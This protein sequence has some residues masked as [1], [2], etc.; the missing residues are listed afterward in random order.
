[1][2]GVSPS[3]L[4]RPPWERAPPLPPIPTHPRA[5]PAYFSGVLWWGVLVL[6]GVGSGWC[7][8]VCPVS[9][10]GARVALRQTLRGRLRTALRK[11]LRRE[12]RRVL[13]PGVRPAL[14]RRVMGG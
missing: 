14:R 13:C 7:R 8:V 9:R 11:G 5:F 3:P 10:P 12:L 6:V 2:T 1:M 4:S